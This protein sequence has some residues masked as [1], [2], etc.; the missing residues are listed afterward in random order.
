MN[1]TQRL[2]LLNLR[3]QINILLE[4]DNSSDLT[5][6]MRFR[7]IHPQLSWLA[8][9]CRGYAYQ[10]IEPDGLGNPRVCFEFTY[11]RSERPPFENI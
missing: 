1:P 10:R 5:E 11:S 8:Y 4:E 2:E 9:H 6:H 3:A 7:R